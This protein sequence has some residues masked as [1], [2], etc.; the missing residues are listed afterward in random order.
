[1]GFYP[2]TNTY[3]AVSFVTLGESLSLSFSFESGHSN[4][5]YLFRFK[6]K[7]EIHKRA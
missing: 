5:S 3:S 4:G 6:E 2:V 1:M 7:G